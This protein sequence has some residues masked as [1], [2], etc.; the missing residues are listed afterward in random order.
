MVRSAAL[1]AIS[2]HLEVTVAT[3]CEAE[4]G[5]IWPR[6]SIGLPAI[7]ARRAARLGCSSACT[8]SRSAA[9]SSAVMPV[10]GVRRLVFVDCSGSRSPPDISDIGLDPRRRRGLH[11][12]VAC[13]RS[14][15]E[16]RNNHRHRPI[17]EP[18][19]CRMQT[20][21][22]GRPFTTGG[23]RGHPTRQRARLPCVSRVP[24][25]PPMLP[26][27]NVFADAKNGF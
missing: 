2:R 4:A 11:T 5:S 12:T 18:R 9:R 16:A 20:R 14:K 6:S 15:A 24:L 27:K 23:C 13:P 8:A 25:A 19:R 7:F 21:R 22:G 10:A 17:L 1:R 26:S 3:T